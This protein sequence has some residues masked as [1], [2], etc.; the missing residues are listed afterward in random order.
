EG[1]MMVIR[2][3]S[4]DVVI[5][6]EIGKREDVQALL[7]VFH[8]GVTIICTVHGSSLT[9]VKKRLSLRPLF[10]EAIFKRFIYLANDDN[11]EFIY[12]IHDER[13]KLLSTIAER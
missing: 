8:A 6:D 2:S 3:L 5:V 7:D 12:D 13:H 10:T 1:M 9:E 11:N 4:P